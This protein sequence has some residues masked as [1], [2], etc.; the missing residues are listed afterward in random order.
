MPIAQLHQKW[1][2]ADS[3]GE[4]LERAATEWLAQI[5]AD[6]SVNPKALDLNS[7]IDSARLTRELFTDQL[8]RFPTDTFKKHRS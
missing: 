7:A 1:R 3:A 4:V 6:E 2:E 5:G 8:R